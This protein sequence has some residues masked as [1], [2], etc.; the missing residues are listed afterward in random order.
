VN[1][2]H[3]DSKKSRILWSCMYLS[4]ISLQNLSKIFPTTIHVVWSEGVLLNRGWGILLE[5]GME[6]WAASWGLL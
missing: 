3:R 2:K 5:K 6:N 1:T 4:P